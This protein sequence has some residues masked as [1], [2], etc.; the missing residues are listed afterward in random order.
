MYA[1]VS[2]NEIHS[3]SENGRYI[4][5][6]NGECYA[7]LAFECSTFTS[8]Q[9][10]ELNNMT[11]DSSADHV[12][13]DRHSL[14]EELEPMVDLKKILSADMN[15]GFDASDDLIALGPQNSCQL[16]LYKCVLDGCSAAFEMLADLRTHFICSHQTKGVF[17]IFTLLIGLLYYSVYISIV[18]Y[19]RFLLIRVNNLKSSLV[20]SH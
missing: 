9:E 3:T 1:C 18:S 19:G 6:L 14:T 16:W 12:G 8:Q 10:F 11:T 13:M 2:D 5:L 4:A 7:N 15:D 20:L 17:L